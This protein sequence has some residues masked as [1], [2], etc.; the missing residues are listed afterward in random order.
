MQLSGSSEL[1]ER[2][3]AGDHEALAVLWRELNPLLLRYLRGRAGQRGDD[4]AAEAWLSAA[5]GLVRFDGD[6]LAFRRWLF[7]IARH[8]LVDEM[9]RQARRPE[10]LTA[11]PPEGWRAD[12]AL[13]AV[14][15]LDGALAIVRQLPP[16]QADAVLLRIV[17]DFDVAEVAEMMRRSEGAVRVLVHRGLRRLQALVDA[18]VTDV[19]RAS[20]Y[21][22]K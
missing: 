18:D 15:E 2:A 6:E 17:G 3:K 10:R 9:R 12:P 7:T 16:D 8:R 1:I 13:R 14:D 19:D 11:N 22:G 5:R 21:R 20:L 4:I